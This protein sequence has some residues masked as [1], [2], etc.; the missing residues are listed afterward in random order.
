MALSTPSQS[1][2]VVVKEIDLTGGVPNVQSTTGAIVGNFRWGPVEQ[3]VL[4]DN[5]ATLVDTFA[6]PDSD[7]TIDWHSANYFL[8]YSGSLQTVREITSHARN[9]HSNIGQ[10]AADSANSLPARVVKNEAD[11]D[12][13]FGGL[14]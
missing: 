6:S 13:Q 12:N 4:I 11:F 9:A 1:P 7:N 10:L 5:E 8:K 2:A 14:D 3:R